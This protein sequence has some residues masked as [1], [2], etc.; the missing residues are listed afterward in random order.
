MEKLI[1]VLEKRKNY[2]TENTDFIHVLDKIDFVIKLIKDNQLQEKFS[3]ETKEIISLNSDEIANQIK[4]FLANDD[5]KYIQLINY[6]LSKIYSSILSEFDNLKALLIDRM[7]TIESDLSTTLK[8]YE[9]NISLIENSISSINK[10]ESKSTV[11][12]KKIENS[13]KET[14]QIINKYIATI[15]ED[16]EKRIDAKRVKIDKDLAKYQ[17]S[18]EHRIDSIVNSFRENIN[19]WDKKFDELEGKKAILKKL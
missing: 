5:E 2:K 10:L 15:K 8:H 19:S 14:T 9:D 7:T 11:L 1:K 16:T 17:K 13:H 12:T 4:N 18:I 6:Y 3:L